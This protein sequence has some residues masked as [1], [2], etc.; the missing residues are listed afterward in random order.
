MHCIKNSEVEN[1]LYLYFYKVHFNFNLSYGVSREREKLFSLKV[2]SDSSVFCDFFLS[3]RDGVTSA[4]THFV[5]FPLN[6]TVS[7]EIDKKITDNC[8]R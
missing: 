7:E 2:S 8:Y 1:W 3:K 5:S 6:R 4:S